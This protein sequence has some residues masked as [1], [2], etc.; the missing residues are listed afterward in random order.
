MIISVFDNTCV[1]TT[2]QYQ[3]E[4]VRSGSGTATTQY[5]V[6]YLHL[7]NVHTISYVTIAVCTVILEMEIPHHVLCRGNNIAI[8]L[9]KIPKTHYSEIMNSANI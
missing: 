7:K 2:L 4:T 9:Q 8:D 1:D 3:H 5:V 6:G